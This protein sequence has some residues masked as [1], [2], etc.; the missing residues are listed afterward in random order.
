M[1]TFRLTDPAPVMSGLQPRRDRRLR[2][3][4]F[5][6]L[7]HGNFCTRFSTINA[8][9]MSRASA[10]I[11]ELGFRERILAQLLFYVCWFVY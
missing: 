6:G 5:V 3:S 10:K 7:F 2:C 8:M 4:W 1:P 9:L 11:I